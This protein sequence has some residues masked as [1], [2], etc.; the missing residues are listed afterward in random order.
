MSH[1]CPIQQSYV[2]LLVGWHNYQ[3]SNNFTEVLSLPPSLNVSIK[4]INN[5][6]FCVYF[7]NCQIFTH[8]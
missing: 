1:I 8:G 6:L 5:P 3:I 2:F 7:K 4:L